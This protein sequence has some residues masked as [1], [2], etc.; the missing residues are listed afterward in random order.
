MLPRAKA[1]SQLD[2]RL[3]A[4]LAW[5]AVTVAAQALSVA[6]DTSRL[7]PFSPIPVYMGFSR[8]LR[9]DSFVTCIVT[10][11]GE[12]GAVAAGVVD[13][14]V[15]RRFDAALRRAETGEARRHVAALF[16]EYLRERTP[17]SDGWQGLRMYR[18]VWDLRRREIVE[19]HLLAEYLAP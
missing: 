5:T 8:D 9:A 11:E 4:V 2:L 7:W 12:R 6:L 13:H 18:R 10:P 14:R 3:C 16:F 19:S 1:L 15:V 17:A